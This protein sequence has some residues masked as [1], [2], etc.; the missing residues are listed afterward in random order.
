MVTQVSYPFQSVV[1]SNPSNGNLKTLV[2]VVLLGMFL[3][4]LYFSYNAWQEEEKKK[5]K[6]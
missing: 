4:K 5:A 3:F 6:V 2:F 1:P